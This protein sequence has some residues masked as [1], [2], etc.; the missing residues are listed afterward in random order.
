M[1]LELAP[2][3]AGEFGER[4]L[5]AAA[6]ALQQHLLAANRGMVRRGPLHPFRMPFPAG[7]AVSV[8][9]GV[10]AVSA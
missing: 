6:G 8:S 10:A 9:F 5:V 7:F 2:V 4:P 1:H 3:G